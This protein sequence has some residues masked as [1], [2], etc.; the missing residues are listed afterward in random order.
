MI[1]GIGIDTIELHRVARVYASYGQRFLEKIYTEGERDYF[2]R[3]SDPVPRIAGRFVVKEAC[4]KALGTGWSRGVRWRDIEVLRHSSGKPYVRLH[5]EAKR[6]LASLD[7]SE[8]H[9]TITHS[10]EYATAIVI[11]E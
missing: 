6:I 1:K 8:V 5:G 10:R 7:A 3:W 11:F 9:C 4:M 2:R